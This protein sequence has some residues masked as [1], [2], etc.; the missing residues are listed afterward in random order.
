MI[1]K[2]VTFLCKTVS[3]QLIKKYK[4]IVN[5]LIK[6]MKKQF[7]QSSKTLHKLL[8]TK[9]LKIIFFDHHPITSK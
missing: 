8:L 6:T 5:D 2:R 1:L 4:F 7:K 3:T 9:I